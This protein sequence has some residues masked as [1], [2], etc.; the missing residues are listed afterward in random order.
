MDFS[1]ILPKFFGLIHPQTD[2]G[3]PYFA[4]EQFTGLNIAG[5]C[6]KQDRLTLYIA[7]YALKKA[8]TFKGGQNRPY[9]ATEQFT[10]LNIAGICHG[11]VDQPKLPLIH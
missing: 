4:A 3:R 8:L 10:R 5:R 9:F 2:Q 1:R 11:M 7:A 6:H